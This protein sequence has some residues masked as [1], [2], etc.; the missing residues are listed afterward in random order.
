MGNSVVGHAGL[1]G[2]FLLGPRR[3]DALYT[4]EEIEIAR[5]TGERLIDSAA[6]SALSQRLMQI[7]RERMATTQILDQRTRRVLHDEVLP[8]IHTA[9][10]SLS[11]GKA[12][13]VIFKQLSDAHQ[14]VS[15]LLRELPPTV[16]PDIARLGL[17]AALRKMV[18]VEFPQAFDAVDWR[19]AE[20]WR[21]RSGGC[22]RWMRRRSTMPHGRRCATPPN[23]PGRRT[24]APNCGWRSACTWPRAGC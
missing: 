7:Q 14:E 15:N 11:G 8:L 9:M 1:T 21:R 3:G 6:G 17:L 23:T 20:G 5:S 22:G 2:I 16:A 12:P 4:Q 13:D 18:A 24:A 10:L 19:C